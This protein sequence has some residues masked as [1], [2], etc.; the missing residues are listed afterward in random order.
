MLYALLALALNPAA[1]AAELPGIA[2]PFD[3][4]GGQWVLSESLSEDY[5]SAGAEPGWVLTAI[6][7]REF[8][9]GETASRQ[10]A[11]GPAR[12]V[13][14]LFQIPLPEPEED[15]EL[16]PVLPAVPLPAVPVVGS[17]PGSHV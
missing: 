7:G 12:E 3:E 1:E 10:V 6:D 14:L 11:V 4:A 17:G 16:E 15:D 13:Q 9:D 2:L 8:V 5:V